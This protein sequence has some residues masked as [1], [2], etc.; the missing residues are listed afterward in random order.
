MKKRQNEEI[1]EIEPPQKSLE[2]ILKTEI[3]VAQEI[4]NAKENAEHAINAARD[5]VGDL[6]ENILKEAR[7]EREQMLAAGVDEA[8]K[9]AQKHIDKAQQSSARF[10]ENGQKFIDQAIDTVIHIV[11]DDEGGSK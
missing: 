2:R 1:I 8:N 4:S 3:T 6:K 11:L 10:F 7:K 5:E 9:K